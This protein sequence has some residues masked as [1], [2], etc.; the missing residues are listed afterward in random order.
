MSKEYDVI[1]VGGGIS[2]LTAGLSSARLGRSTLVLTGDALGGHLLSIEKVEGYPGFPE[3]VPGYDLCPMT[4]EQ[5][6]AAGAE[7]ALAAATALARDGDIWRVASANGEQRARAV[8]VATGTS[9]MALGVPGEETL[10]GKGVSHCASC[11]APLMRNE[12]VVVVGGG[13]SALQEALTLAAHAAEVVVVH[14]G[15]APIAQATFRARVAAQPK[16]TLRANSEVAAILGTAAVTGV[17]IRAANGAATDDVE[18]AGVFVYIGLAPSSALVA[19]LA[20]L[21]PT[22]HVAT[23]AEL[24]TSARGVLAAGTVRAGAAG[25]AVAAAGDGARAALAADEFLRTGS[26][27]NS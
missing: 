4:Q 26:W 8:I 16:I 12:R 23:D 13:D 7:L 10:R 18:A 19:Q 3:G 2:G 15:A 27:P 9:L 20:A 17:R 21:A 1:V 11:D 5:A 14:R 22:R 25:R 6:V 24:R